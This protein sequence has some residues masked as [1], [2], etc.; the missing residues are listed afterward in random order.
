MINFLKLYRLFKTFTN[1]S[2]LFKTFRKL[3]KT[4]TNF[5]INTR[6]SS[7]VFVGVGESRRREK[8]IEEKGENLRGREKTLGGWEKT[9]G[10]WEKTLGRWEKNPRGGGPRGEGRMHAGHAHFCSKLYPE[11]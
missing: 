10:R 5:P 4:F 1:F 7:H 3:F 11:L 8:T 9:F 2:K 6:H